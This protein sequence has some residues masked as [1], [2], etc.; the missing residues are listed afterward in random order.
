VRKIIGLSFGFLVLVSNIQGQDYGWWNSLVQWDGKTPWQQYLQL[1]TSGLGPNA[2]PVPMFNSLGVQKGWSFKQQ[3]RY[4]HLQGDPTFDLESRIDISFSDRIAIAMWMVPLEYYRTSEE[5]RDRRKIRQFEATG[6]TSG[7]FYFGTYFHL[8]LENDRRPDIILSTNI[9]TA[10]GNN[11]EGGRV[12]DTPGYYFDA[13][14]AKTFG[15]LRPYLVGGLYVYQTFD[16]LHHQNDAFLYGLGFHHQHNRLKTQVEWA[17][18]FGYL[19]IGD[20]PS[21]LRLNFDFESNSNITY[22][23]GI[24]YGLNDF[25]YTSFSLGAIYAKK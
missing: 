5:V 22:T 13:T 8:L 19:E 24:Q 3:A 9:K 10:S 18:Y 4:H 7:D 21:V 2:L 14:F 23:A 16:G 11:V 20:Q 1:S 6:F 15:Q 12:T 17:G 25:P